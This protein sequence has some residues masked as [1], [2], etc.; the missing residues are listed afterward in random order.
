MHA[1]SAELGKGPPQAAWRGSVV[2]P[3]QAPLRLAKLEKRKPEIER[4]LNRTK[5]ERTL[6]RTKCERTLNRTKCERTLNA[7]TE[8]YQSVNAH[9]H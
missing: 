3:S 6:N 8:P 9:C 5:C 7:H 1:P 4:T 2:H